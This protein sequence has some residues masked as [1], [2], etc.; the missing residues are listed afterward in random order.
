VSFSILPAGEGI[1]IYNGWADFQFKAYEG[2]WKV[3]S[4]RMLSDE[5]GK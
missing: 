2:S 5:V 3:V 1:G 4:A